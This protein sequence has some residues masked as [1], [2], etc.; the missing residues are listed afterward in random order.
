MKINPEL[1]LY[2]L[3]TFPIGPRFSRIEVELLRWA[4]P[5]CTSSLSLNS[6]PQESQLNGLA[7]DRVSLQVLQTLVCLL[8]FYVKL[9]SK[10]V[11][12]FWCVSVTVLRLFCNIFHHLAQ[13]LKHVHLNPFPSRWLSEKTPNDSVSQCGLLIGTVS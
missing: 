13:A 10:E 8:H 12:H 3:W 6:H 5:R 2:G 7:F 9:T 1:H 4:K 11:G